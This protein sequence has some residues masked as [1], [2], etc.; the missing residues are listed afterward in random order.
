MYESGKQSGSWASLLAVDTVTGQTALHVAAANPSS[1]SDQLEIMW[2]LLQAGVKVEALDKLGHSCVTLAAMAGNTI[3]MSVILEHMLFQPQGP[4]NAQSLLTSCDEFNHFDVLVHAVLADRKESVLSLLGDY[5]Y[6]H[7]QEARYCPTARNILHLAAVNGS[8]NALEALLKLCFDDIV[9]LCSAADRNGFMPLAYAAAN[10]TRRHLRDGR[11][12]KCFMPSSTA[13]PNVESHINN[14]SALLEVLQVPI[15]ALHNGGANVA[16]VSNLNPDSRTW[17]TLVCD[18]RC[19]RDVNCCIHSEFVVAL[20]ETGLVDVNQLHGL[21]PEGGLSSLFLASLYG[22]I[23]VVRALLENGAKQDI[24][25]YTPMQAAAATNNRA[26]VEL[27]MTHN[28]DNAKRFMMERPVNFNGTYKLQDTPL[29]IAIANSSSIEEL[30]PFLSE[31]PFFSGEDLQLAIISGQEELVRALL[32]AGASPFATTEL[33]GRLTALAT[34]VDVDNLPALRL[35]LEHIETLSEAVD[36][37]GR[38]ILHHVCELGRSNALLM[39][40]EELDT[41]I[42]YEPDRKDELSILIR[43]VPGLPNGRA[44]PLE[45][46]ARQDSSPCYKILQSY[47]QESGFS[48]SELIASAAPQTFEKLAPP[49]SPPVELKPPPPVVTSSSTASTSS[50]SAFGSN[51]KLGKKPKTGSPRANN[52]KRRGGSSAASQDYMNL[53]PSQQVG[54]DTLKKAVSAKLADFVASHSGRGQLRSSE[55]I[56]DIPGITDEVLSSKLEGLLKWLINTPDPTPYFKV[57][58][59]AQQHKRVS[60]ALL[61]MNI[62]DVCLNESLKTTN[63]LNMQSWLRT[64]ALL[65]RNDTPFLDK[66]TLNLIV[67]LLS[68]PLFM[69]TSKAQAYLMVTINNECA[70]HPQVSNLI[71]SKLSDRDNKTALLRFFSCCIRTVQDD[72]ASPAGI[73]LLDLFTHI[74]LKEDSFAD[75]YC[76]V[77]ANLVNAPSALACIIQSLNSLY[78]KAIDM[79]ASLRMLQR[80]AQYFPVRV[81]LAGALLPLLRLSTARPS[82]PLGAATTISAHGAFSDLLKFANLP[83]Q[84]LLWKVMR[85]SLF[86]DLGLTSPALEARTA[87]CDAIVCLCRDPTIQQQLIADPKYFDML[88]KLFGSLVPSMKPNGH[89]GEGEALTMRECLLALSFLWN[90]DPARITA[91]LTIPNALELL[92]ALYHTDGV[93]A[94]ASRVIQII[95]AHDPQQCQSLLSSSPLTMRLYQSFAEKSGFTV[96]PSQ[97]VPLQHVEPFAVPKWYT[98]A[99]GVLHEDLDAVTTCAYCGVNN[100]AKSLTEQ[101]KGKRYCS[102]ECQNADATSI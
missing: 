8:T 48:K 42:P 63:P 51:P 81:V 2:M 52:G 39:I 12:P 89:I 15:D 21:G 50:A 96:S 93:S 97:L 16:I 34:A 26:L 37:Q 23:P 7:V 47:L 36:H 86:I 65:H 29:T 40:Q 33:Y 17:S 60:A 56:A 55:F 28:A 24:G 4:L 54:M 90:Q 9:S 71:V 10:C 1:S 43:P 3:G 46:A 45:I 101:S 77:M 94:V 18:P 100:E 5:E 19:T 87:A 20:L 58:H 79:T 62:V 73:G 78:T 41:Q 82:D 99:D 76:R 80:V 22:H 75:S 6:C 85:H 95:W 84:K 14:L 27:L 61:E 44:S 38:N 53:T 83:L 32:N 98:H 70:A 13:V 74:F 59:G 66:H 30:E 25:A 64:L 67:R 72:E 102:P 57:L 92:L 68:Y 91:V 88:L 31:V 35:V 11:L 69:E 49:P